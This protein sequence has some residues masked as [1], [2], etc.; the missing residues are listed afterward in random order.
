KKDFQKTDF[1]LTNSMFP[2]NVDELQVDNTSLIN[3]YTYQIVNESITSR[4]E[5]RNKVKIK[6][7]HL[8]DENSIVIGKNREKPFKVKGLIGISAM[9]YGA[10]SKSAVKAL[11]QGVTISGGS[12]MNTGE[13]GI[14]P[15]HLS[16]VYEVMNTTELPTDKPSRKIIK[17]V[18]ANPNASNFELEKRF[19]KD[20]LTTVNDLVVKGI[21][22]EKGADLIFQVG[23]G[24]FGARKNGKY[25]E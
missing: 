25:C 7:W 12:F 20:A 13:G 5:K 1:Y 2:L 17:Y 21:L 15:Y 14:S 22:K 11:A 18:S 9:S 4:K 10:L 3:T 16:K 19:G 23:S 24:L 6:P 8:T